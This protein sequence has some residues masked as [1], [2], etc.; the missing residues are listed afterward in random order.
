M[1]FPLHTVEVPDGSTGQQYSDRVVIGT[2]LG[3]ANLA[4]SGAGT[5]VTTAVAFPN[6]ALPANYQVAVTPDQAAMISVTGKTANGF[7]VV[8]TPDIGTTL[9]VGTFDVTVIA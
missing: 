3:I 9:G 7:N 2:Q 1:P 4:G 6:G 8:M 5:A